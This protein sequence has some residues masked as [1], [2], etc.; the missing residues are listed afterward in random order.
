MRND[1]RVISMLNIARRLAARGHRLQMIKAVLNGSGYP[2]A[3]AFMNQ[4]RVRTELRDI[5]D[6]ARRRKVRA[7]AFNVRKEAHRGGPPRE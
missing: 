3:L 5:A 7:A 6:R 1:E 4:P 2:E